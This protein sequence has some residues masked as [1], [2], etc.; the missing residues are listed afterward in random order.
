MSQKEIPAYF[1]PI[2]WSYNFEKLDP[3]KN[4][5]DIVLNTINYGNLIHW[6]WI[7]QKYGKKEVWQTVKQSRPS[8][9][10]SGARRLAEILFG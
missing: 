10:R 9:L 1:R 4:E 6:F 2:L 8:E 7:S 3:Q 5:R